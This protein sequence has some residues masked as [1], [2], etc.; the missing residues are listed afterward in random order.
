MSNALCTVLLQVR[1]LNTH[2]HVSSFDLTYFT[3][4]G[5]DNTIC[6]YGSIVEFRKGSP[7]KPVLLKHKLQV[8]LINTKVVRD[9][10][11]LVQ[12]VA[13]LKKRVPIVVDTI[14]DSMDQLAVTALENLLRLNDVD[15]PNQVALKN[16][17]V[18]ADIYNKVEVSSALYAS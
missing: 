4:L 3:L 18:V 7:L 15:V 8:M 17:A 5:L 11:V 10:K 6:C 1:E 12:H 16:D 14:L 13:E 9:T 2:S